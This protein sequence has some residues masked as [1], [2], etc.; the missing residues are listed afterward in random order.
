MLFGGDKDKTGSSTG[1]KR[2]VAAIAGPHLLQSPLSFYF[3]Y[4][5]LGVATAAPSFPFNLKLGS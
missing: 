3:I 5:Q 1:L 2:G 4:L